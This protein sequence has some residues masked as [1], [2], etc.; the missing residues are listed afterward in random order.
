VNRIH[1]EVTRTYSELRNGNITRILTTQRRSIGRDAILL[2]ACGW[3]EQERTFWSHVTNMSYADG[4]RSVV[5]VLEAIVERV[6]NLKDTLESWESW[7][8]EY[9]IDLRAKELIGEERFNKLTT[10][11]SK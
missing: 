9:W 4:I 8:F 10:K 5:E 1:K 2:C 11:E 6:Y 3:Y 7:E